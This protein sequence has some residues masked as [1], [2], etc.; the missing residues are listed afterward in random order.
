M[1]ALHAVVLALVGVALLVA[2][3]AVVAGVGW[4]LVA[5][6]VLVL[7]GAVLLYPADGGKT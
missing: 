5:A 1:T 2:G 7:A 4:A 6:G 3:V